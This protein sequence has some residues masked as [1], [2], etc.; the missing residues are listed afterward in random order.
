MRT[1]IIISII[2]SIIN[3]S[4]FNA[5]PIIPVNNRNIDNNLQPPFQNL[6]I[7]LLFIYLYYFISSIYKN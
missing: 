5:I 7:I 2:I 1:S 4:V 3:L 6:F